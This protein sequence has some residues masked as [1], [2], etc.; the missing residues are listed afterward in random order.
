MLEIIALLGGIFKDWLGGQQKLQLAQQD[1][2]AAALETQARQIRDQNSA[3]SAWE[4]AALAD[5]DKWLRRISFAIF[6]YPLVWAAFDPNGVATYFKVA[7]SSLPPWYFQT[8]MTIT[9]V[10]W[11]VATLKNGLPS[12]V[13]GVASVIKRGKKDA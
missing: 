4:I 13:N 5:S 7:L 12:L 11:S 2:D 1:R 8:Y 10:V 9:G 6:S 3:N